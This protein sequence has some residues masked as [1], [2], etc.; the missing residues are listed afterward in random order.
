MLPSRL[1]GCLV[2]WGFLGVSCAR[3]SVVPLDD[4]AVDAKSS[5]QPGFDAG[6]CPE[7]FTLA[8]VGPD[9]G[10]D[11]QRVCV[12]SLRCDVVLCSCNGLSYLGCESPG[13]SFA[14]VGACAADAACIGRGEE[15]CGRDPKCQV[16]R[17]RP[18]EDYCADRYDRSV[19][20]GCRGVPE[21][22]GEAFTWGSEPG[23]DRVLVFSNTCIPIGWRQAR[24]TCAR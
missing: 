4:A 15:A 20:A 2:L 10:G 16:V 12:E 1:V 19:Y 18:P 7:G 21:A 24:S 22:C 9:C 3:A 5:G 14:A 13:S 17:G 11:P 8:T 6:P 23:T